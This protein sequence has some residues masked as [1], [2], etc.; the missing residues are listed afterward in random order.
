VIRHCYKRTLH[1]ITNHYLLENTQPFLRLIYKKIKYTYHRTKQTLTYT[2][3]SPLQRKRHLNVE[4]TATLVITGMTSY[5]KDSEGHR[6]WVIKCTGC[7]YF[8]FPCLVHLANVSSK[9]ILIQ[10]IDYKNY[11]TAHRRNFFLKI[12]SLFF[13]RSCRILILPCVWSGVSAGVCAFSICN[14]LYTIQLTPGHRKSTPYFIYLS[15][16]SN[17]ELFWG[18]GGEQR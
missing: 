7:V 6:L 9:Y 8:S 3:T 13:C 18:A 14:I 5:T 15:N 2:H 11:C 12:G 4:Q 10:A 17:H 16:P 1:T